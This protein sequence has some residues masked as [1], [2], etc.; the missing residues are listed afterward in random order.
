MRFAGVEP[1]SNAVTRALQ[2]LSE[3]PKVQQKLYE[4]IK[5]KFTSDDIPDYEELTQNQFIDAVVQEVLRL[6][7]NILFL[8]RTAV[9]VR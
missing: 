8:S 7:G 6:A 3:N 9:V 1:V 4:E 2:F 5:S